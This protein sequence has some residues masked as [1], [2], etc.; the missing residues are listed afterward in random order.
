[1][2]REGNNNMT[3]ADK[4]EHDQKILRI[5]MINAYNLILGK[6]TYEDL[7]DRDDQGMWLPDGFKD[8]ES[9]PHLIE[10]F[11]ETEEYEKC[12]DL[13]NKQKELQKDNQI[14]ELTKIFNSTK[15]IPPK[16][17]R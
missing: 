7:L 6:I 9:I 16:N 15:W 1:M 13:V 10:Y 8:G 11:I 2:D 14:N 3:Y 4:L 12:Q 5:A 17:K